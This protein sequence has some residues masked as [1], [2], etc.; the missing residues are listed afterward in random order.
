M[1]RI[2]LL[3][4]ALTMV[5]PCALA[6]ETTTYAPIET[7]LNNK[8][9]APAPYA[10]NPDGY[11]PDNGG[12]ADDSLSITVETHYW[13]DDI[14]QVENPG[15][16]ITTVLAVHVK[17][18]DASQFRTA[19]ASPYPSKQ[20]ARVEQMAQRNNAVLAINGDFFN[21]HDSGIAYRNTRKMRFNA[22]N[23]RELLIIDEQGDFHYLR[24]TS[25]KAWDAYI[26]GGGTVLHTFWFGPNLVLENGE[27]MTTFTNNE[28]N[29]PWIK[30]QR[31]VIGQVGPLE[32]LI[33]ACEGPESTDYKDQG[34][35]LGQ[36][37]KLAVTYGLDNAYNLDGGSSTTV[38]LNNTKINSLSNPK[39]REVG[40]CI[41]F[42]TLIPSN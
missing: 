12:Y 5:L 7:W 26:A 6:E 14:V 2:L 25:Q 23:L 18:T 30:A 13:T 35:T 22:N 29:G 32:Y 34:F 37:A 27:P 42:A 11:L 40:D 8:Q 21:H 31:L 3:L 33:L 38:V 10:P 1:K 4:L 20:I 9:P 24:P 41:Y 15:D 28:N 36:M 16:G 17:L 39:R 19:L